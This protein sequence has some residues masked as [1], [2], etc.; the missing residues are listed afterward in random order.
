[1]RKLLV[2]ALLLNAALL[3]GRF[4]QELPVNAQGGNLV[5]EQ[6]RTL[7]S[8]DSNGDGGIDLSDAVHLLT[9][10][11]QGGSEPEMCLADPADLA[12][13]QAEL[14]TCE[15]Q[16]TACQA[17]MSPSY[18]ACV[19]AAGRFTDN[20]DGTVTDNC[21]GLMWQQ[22][23]ADVNG[24]GMQ[25]GFDVMSWNA[26]I[27]YAANLNF[28][29]HDDWRLPTVQELQTIVDYAR[30]GPAIDP[31]FSAESDFYWSSTLAAGGP[32]FA[33][34]VFFD[35]GGVGGGGVIGDNHV[36]AVRSGT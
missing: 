20:E 23:T 7:H 12:A 21:T 14:A 13:S 19:G 26:A 9:W 8:I 15:A 4:W 11:F 22:D 16:L 27:T 3:A 25:D 35:H 17:G 1:M 28:A 29:G 6:D 32:G 33:W 30:R 31:V 5:C 10:L 24:D 18:P 2:F 36:R 34:G